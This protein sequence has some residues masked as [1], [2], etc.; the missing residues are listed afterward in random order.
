MLKRPY[1]TEVVFFISITKMKEIGI[2]SFHIMFYNG[3]PPS[4][5][6]HIPENIRTPNR[7]L[8]IGKN[9]NLNGPIY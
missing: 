4:P 8:R 7:N 3:T 9:Q 1:W 6:F 5:K 2:L